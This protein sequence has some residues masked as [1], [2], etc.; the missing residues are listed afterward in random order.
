MQ[1]KKEKNQELKEKL[2]ERVRQDLE[3]ENKYLKDTI[4][5][6]EIIVKEK[7]KGE[8]FYKEK[9]KKIETIINSMDED[10]KP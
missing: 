9:I 6:I 10:K 1:E 8:E 7:G 4:K 3:D 5:D 2:H